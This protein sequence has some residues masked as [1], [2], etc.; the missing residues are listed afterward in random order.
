DADRRAQ[1]AYAAFRE[2]EMLKNILVYQEKLPDPQTLYDL[3]KHRSLNDAQYQVLRNKVKE[4]DFYRNYKDQKGY[5]ELREYLDDKVGVKP[6]SQKGMILLTVL[7]ALA[8][9]F[10]RWRDPSAAPFIVISLFTALFLHITLRRNVAIDLTRL[11]MSFVMLV[12]SL[13]FLIADDEASMVFG[14]LMGCVTLLAAVFFSILILI[15]AF[16]RIRRQ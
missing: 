14:F 15:K 4:A 5:Q 11:I 2:E 12:P 9:V 13:A 1:Q 3:L 10:G 7:Y 8:A 6:L 16:Q